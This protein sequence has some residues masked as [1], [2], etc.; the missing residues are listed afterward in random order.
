MLEYLEFG[1]GGFG[2]LG[3]KL[4]INIKNDKVICNGGSPFWDD[5]QFETVHLT[6]KQS[7]VFLEKLDA[8]HINRWKASY[9]PIGYIVMDG[10]QWELEY[11]EQE[12]RC[13]HITGDNAYPD[14]WNA[15]I[16]LLDEILPSAGL[17]DENQID[18]LKMD[19]SYSYEIENP[20][21]PKKNYKY[22]VNETFTV[23]AITQDIC[24][25]RQNSHGTR[26]LQEC[27]YP[28]F[29]ASI[30]ALIDDYA[31]MFDTITDKELIE[32][33]PSITLEYKK[34]GF[35]ERKVKIPYCR[36]T[37]TDNWDDFVKDVLKEL[38]SVIIPGD[39]WRGY[40]G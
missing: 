13:R 16:G 26:Q 12:K 29:D 32:A 4:S 21:E 9:F 14:N 20:I 31:D 37:V 24:Y 15:F 11:K 28:E 23:N 22:K 3:V 25:V 7:V 5:E 17:I 33:V 30:F 35:P 1:I 10:T 18:Y 39:H 34:H 19:Y 40:P 36:W 8:L 38:K 27:H 6:K 2:D